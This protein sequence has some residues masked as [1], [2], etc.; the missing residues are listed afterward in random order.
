MLS[1]QTRELFFKQ[2]SLRWEQQHKDEKTILRS[3]EI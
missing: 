1:G 3:F 2:G